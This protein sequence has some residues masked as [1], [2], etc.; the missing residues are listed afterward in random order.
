MNVDI[1]GIRVHVRKRIY[2]FFIFKSTDSSI[3]RHVLNIY[4]HMRIYVQYMNGCLKI[5]RNKSK[6]R[7][8]TRI[9]STEILMHFRASEKNRVTIQQQLLF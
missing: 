2:C 5:A 7:Q 1:S 8:M 6:R 3:Q 4:L 9:S